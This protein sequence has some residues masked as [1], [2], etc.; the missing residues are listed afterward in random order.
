MTLVA[1]WSAGVCL[2]ALC[3]NS[4]PLGGVLQPRT[5]E[6]SQ[7]TAAKKTQEN[8]FVSEFRVSQTR[9]VRLQTGSIYTGS[10][11]QVSTEDTDA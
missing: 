11:C 8:S 4:E 2:A 10:V 9:F 6:V 7:L 5:L 1:L 3:G